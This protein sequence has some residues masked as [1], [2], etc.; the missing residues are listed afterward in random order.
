MKESKWK[1]IKHSN[2]DEKKKNQKN[3]V[4]KGILLNNLEGRALCFKI[5]ERKHKIAPL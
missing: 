5:F 1:K 4:H 3:E 2:G